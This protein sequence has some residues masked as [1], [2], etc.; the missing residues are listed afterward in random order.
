MSRTYINKKGDKI[1]VS[2]EH[3]DVALEVM[4]ELQKLSPSRR[5]SWPKHKKMMAEEGFEDSDSNENYRCMIKQERKARGELPKAESMAEMITDSKLESIKSAIGDI[6]TAQL[7]SRE[8]FNRLNRVKRE[9]TRDVLLVE[10][11]KNT[12]KDIKFE[13]VDYTPE[14]DDDQEIKKMLV[15]FSDLHY[16]YVGKNALNEYSP[17]I[18]EDVVEEYAEKIINIGRKNNVDEVLVANIGDIVEGMLRNQSMFDTQKTLMTQAV[19]ATNIVIRF[20]VKLSK[21]FKVSYCGIAGNHDRIDKNKKENL[22]GETVMFVSNAMVKQFAEL[23]ENKIE[24]IDLMDEYMGVLNFGMN[25]ILLIHGDRNNIKSPNILSQM[26][27]MLDT[28]LDIVIGGHYHRFSVEEV[29]NGKEV[30][31]FGSF[32]G[33]DDYSIKIGKT[34]SRSQGVILFDSV[35]NYEIR[36]VKL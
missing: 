14:Y 28:N 31:I 11:V 34:S 17:E 3:L 35:G 2:D 23:S 13:S 29:G 4:E 19:E 21:L 15:G 6:K 8:D 32:K 18:A 16:G 25:N 30:A 24:Y 1:E 22:S 33:I 10:A 9:V 7:E 36:Q 5:V 20:L 12:M 26:S 27:S